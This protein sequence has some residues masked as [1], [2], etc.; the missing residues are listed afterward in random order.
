MTR[1]AE[2]PMTG[3]IT[4]PV[5]RVKHTDRLAFMNYI[6][7]QGLNIMKILYEMDSF[8]VKGANHMTGLDQVSSSAF[9]AL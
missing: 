8:I 3:F 9:W 4:K 5:V 7:S 1:D 2:Q 6:Q